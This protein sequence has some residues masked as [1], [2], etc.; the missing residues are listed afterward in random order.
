MNNDNIKIVINGVEV[1]TVPFI[2]VP[3]PIIID[4]SVFNDEY[5]P[6]LN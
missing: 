3:K 5:K 6:S 4:R 1:K 2:Y